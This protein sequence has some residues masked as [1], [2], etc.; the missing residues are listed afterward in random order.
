M[1]GPSERVLFRRCGHMTKTYTGTCHCGAVRFEAD[2]DLSAG[3]FK[4]N[5]PICL[6]T[7]M[8]GAIV[9]PENF[10][11]LSGGDQLKDYQPDRIHHVFCMTCGVRPFG[12]ADD[13]PH[14]GGAFYGVRLACLDN[15]EDG[16][17]AE[18]AVTYSDGR[19]GK[20]DARPAETRYL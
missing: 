7:R 1:D 4:C 18:A 20:Y 6:K 12:R 2:I 10:R 13:D 14:R 9:K 19:N 5:C 17:L 11:L 15:A 16:E 8:W 3:T